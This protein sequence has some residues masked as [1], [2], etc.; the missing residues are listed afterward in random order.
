MINITKHTPTSKQKGA[1]TF[2]SLT[3]PEENV[4]KKIYNMP[5]K[6]VRDTKLQT[7]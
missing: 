4:W 5:F 1:R 3:N 7:I 6:I 2:K